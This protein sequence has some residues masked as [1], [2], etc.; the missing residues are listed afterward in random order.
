[1]SFLNQISDSVKKKRNNFKMF[2]EADDGD[3]NTDTDESTTSPDD[4]DVDNPEDTSTEPEMPGTSL[5]DQFSDDELNDM[6]DMGVTTDDLN[7]SDQYFNNNMSDNGMEDDSPERARANMKL[8]RAYSNM[9]HKYKN[10]VVELKALD[11]SSDRSVVV[12]EFIRRYTDVI[13]SLVDYT[14]TNNEEPFE[15]KYQQFIKFKALFVTI[16]TSLSKI[17]STTAIL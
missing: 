14:N 5:K 3:V 9:Y 17:N 15:I 2:A 11:V 1:M 10:L 16:N 13:E 8:N 7:T 6:N 4:T 12:S